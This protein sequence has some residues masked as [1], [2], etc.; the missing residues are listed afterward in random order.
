M[1][2]MK[3]KVT[4]FYSCAAAKA[5]RNSRS[6]SDRMRCHYKMYSRTFRPVVRHLHGSAVCFLLS[7]VLEVYFCYRSVAATDAETVQ[8]VEVSSFVSLHM[9]IGLSM[10][11]DMWLS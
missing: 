10:T 2:K 9:C 1:Q 5:L 8:R 3:R 7:F 11:R 4:D 6:S